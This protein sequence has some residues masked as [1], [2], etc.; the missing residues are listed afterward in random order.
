MSKTGPKVPKLPQPGLC[1]RCPESEGAKELWRYGGQGKS[2]RDL[3]EAHLADAQRVRSSRYRSLLSRAAGSAVSSDRTSAF[4]ATASGTTSAAAGALAGLVGG[5]QR[6]QVPIGG[7]APPAR[8]EA[9]EEG[10]SGE[11]S[12]ER[13]RRCEAHRRNKAL[14]LH[15]AFTKVSRSRY[16]V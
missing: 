12:G 1:A 4:M 10:T 2:G 3:C 11:S 14:L 16:L 9:R 5:L 15:K 6:Q 7:G 13:A 8:P